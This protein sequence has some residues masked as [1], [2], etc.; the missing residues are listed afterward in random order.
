MRASVTEEDAVR[1]VLK[2]TDAVLRIRTFETAKLYIF[3]SLFL[4]TILQD[5]SLTMRLIQVQLYDFTLFLFDFIDIIKNPNIN[6]Y[7]E[8]CIERVFLF[9]PFFSFF[10]FNCRTTLYAS[11]ENTYFAVE[12]LRAIL[13]LTT[14]KPTHLRHQ[15]PFKIHMRSLCNT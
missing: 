11:N 6:T 3:F 7:M 4:Q 1:G 5:F 13:Y 15:R 2:G 10:L 9:F 8:K 14:T 12:S